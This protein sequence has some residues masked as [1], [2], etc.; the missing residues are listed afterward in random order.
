MH[1][2]LLARAAVE[3]FT[4]TRQARDQIV[5]EVALLDPSPLGPDIAE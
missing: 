1:E 5:T 3:A 4:G 2:I